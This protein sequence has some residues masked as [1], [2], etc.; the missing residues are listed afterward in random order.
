MLQ[1][2]QRPSAGTRCCWKNWQ[3]DCPQKRIW[4]SGIRLDTKIRLYQT[5]IVPVVLYGCET[6]TTT[7]YSCARLD[8][9]DMWALRKILR[10]PY[11]CHITNDEVWSRS[12]YQPLSSIVTSRRLRF[13]G[14][15]AR[16]TKITIVPLLPR[17][18]SLFRIGEGPQ[19]DPVTP[20]YIRWRQTWDLWT[21]VFLLRG[22]KLLG[23]RT[24]ATSWTRLRSGRVR[25]KK[26]A[27]SLSATAIK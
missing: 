27:Y 14:H 19:G 16:L 12:N 15:I 11:T 20:G 9:F 7:K 2:L 8:A 25:H 26:K 23:G 4:K 1:L 17:Y 24:C 10:I 13:F 6:W 5:Y 18:A 21:L 22:E 3:I